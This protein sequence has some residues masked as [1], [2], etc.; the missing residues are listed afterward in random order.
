MTKSTKTKT[1]PITAVLPYSSEL[2]NHDLDS[3]PLPSTEPP[4]EVF[5]SDE[6]LYTFSDGEYVSFD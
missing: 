1:Q 3:E 5:E 2:W 6:G 4:P